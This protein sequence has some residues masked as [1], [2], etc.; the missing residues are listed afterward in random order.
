MRLWD[1]EKKRHITNIVLKDKANSVTI[2]KSGHLLST[3]EGDNTIKLY[4]IQSSYTPQA[5]PSATASAQHLMVEEMQPCQHG[6][7]TNTP[8]L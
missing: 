3:L 7:I 8:L 5:N 2:N 6:T 4:Q 1:L